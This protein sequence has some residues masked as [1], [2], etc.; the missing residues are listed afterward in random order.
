MAKKEVTFSV[1]GSGPFPT[2]MLRYD[3][4][5]P[6]TELDNKKIDM[7][8]DRYDFKR[9]VSLVGPRRPTEARWKSF[10]WKVV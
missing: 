3:S 8:D 7:K 2:D 1:E 4:C 10:G 5:V 9:T 6:E